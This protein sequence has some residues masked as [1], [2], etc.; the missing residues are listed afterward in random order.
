MVAKR[1]V[2]VAKKLHRVAKI[3]RVAIVTIEPHNESK[4]GN[5]YEENIGGN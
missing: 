2:R 4:R 3:K 5:V 1:V